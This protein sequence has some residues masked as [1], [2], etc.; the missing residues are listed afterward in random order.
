[1]DIPRKYKIAFWISVA[2]NVIFVVGLVANLILTQ[3]GYYD[4]KTVNKGLDTL[5]DQNYEEA[6]KAS[7]A[8]DGSD[9]ENQNLA[10]LNYACGAGD[11]QSYYEEGYNNYAESLGLPPTSD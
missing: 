9:E 8:K 2:L 4:E 10:Y 3:T 5:C 6:L 1:M 7:L 11:A